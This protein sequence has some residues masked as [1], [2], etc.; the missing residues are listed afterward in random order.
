MSLNFGRTRGTRPVIDPALLDEGQRED[1]INRLFNLFGGPSPTGTTPNTFPTGGGSFP[2][3]SAI[4]NSRIV[5]GPDGIPRIGSVADTQ[6]SLTGGQVPG[7]SPVTPG[8]STI[9][10]ISPI[11]PISKLALGIEQSPFFKDFLSALT[12]RFTPTGP[13]SQLLENISGRTS[14]EFARRGLGPS[15]VSATGV[16]SSIA[17][18]LVQLRQNRIGNL[19]NALGQSLQ[20]QGLRLGQREQDITTGL[21]QRGQDITQRSQEF[22]DKINQIQGLLNFLTFG[23]RQNL[24]QQG[25]GGFSCGVGLP[26]GG[27]ASGGSGG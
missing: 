8:P 21:T 5:V 16:A 24:G 25:G 23:K 18:A 11:N 2:G 13:E 7:P 10:R 22:A 26:G 1:V 3:P 6:E 12:D 27:G 17:P 14:A 19:G 9:D 20:G 15:P 4:S